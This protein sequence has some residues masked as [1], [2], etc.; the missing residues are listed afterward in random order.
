MKKNII[1]ILTLIW[2]NCFSQNQ[3]PKIEWEKTYGGTLSEHLMSITHTLTGGYMLGGMTASKNGDIKS[4]NHGGYDFW[5]VKTDSLGSMLWEKTY[6]GSNEDDMYS[7]L[8]IS[9][10]GFLLCGSTSSNDGDVKSG[11]HGGSDFWVVKIDSLGNIQWEKTYGGYNNEELYSAITTSDGGFLLGG[12]TQSNDGDIQSGN[13]GKA[14]FW[15]VKIDSVGIIQWEK[16]YGGSNGENVYSIISTPDGGYVL[17]G[18]TTSND[19]DVQYRSLINSPTD[20]WVVKIDSVGKIIWEKCYGRVGYTD[21]FSKV[22][23]TSDGGFLVGGLKYLYSGSCDFWVVKIDN[24]GNIQWEKSYGGS[25]ND[26]LRDILPTSDNGFLLGGYSN[27][28]DGDVQSRYNVLWGDNYWVVKIDEFGIIQW[29]RTY[30]G[31]KGDF[32]YTTLSTNNGGILL[33]GSTQSNDG[34]IKSGNKGGLDF[35]LVKIKPNIIPTY[36][37]E[38]QTM[39]NN[40]TRIY[41]NPIFNE[42]LMIETS[43]SKPLELILYD[44]LGNQIFKKELMFKT[45]KI[46]LGEINGG[47]YILQL[48]DNG[49]ILH[50]QKIIKF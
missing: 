50:Q 43:Y 4:G 15:V 6:G 34:D 36:A 39:F 18:N 20:F 29:E 21:S 45:N 22:V 28:Y 13:H 2:F 23:N 1:L 33:G 26:M 25:N 24:L 41:P 40:I 49:V 30:G 32:I 3:S 9:D 8:Q 7:I 46:D 47:I 5:V 44:V 42:E 14:D 38:L 35:W 16:T 27:S 10:G 19:G 37:N 12:F 31:S 48:M 11:N 17:G